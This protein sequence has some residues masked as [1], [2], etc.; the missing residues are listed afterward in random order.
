V[1]AAVNRDPAHFPDPDRF[2]VGREGNHHL[3]FGQGNHFCLGSQLAKLE[4]E[5]ALGALL[6]RFPDFSG[7]PEPPAWRRSMII[8]GPESVPLT[9]V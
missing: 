8:R 5:V 9:L 1:L 3:A 4:A 2:D 7:A 6:R